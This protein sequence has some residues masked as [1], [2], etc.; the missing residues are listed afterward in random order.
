MPYK[1][2][3]L[4][5]INPKI[6]SGNKNG[7]SLSLPRFLMPTFMPALRRLADYSE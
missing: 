5:N 4:K 1:H 2:K 3:R 6:V 7:E